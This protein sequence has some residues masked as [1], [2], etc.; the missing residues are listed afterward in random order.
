MLWIWTSQGSGSFLVLPA[1]CLASTILGV[2]WGGKTNVL[3][4]CHVCPSARPCMIWYQCLNYLVGFHETRYICSLQNV[5]EKTR[6]KSGA[7]SHTFLRT[8]INVC[9]YVYFTNFVISLLKFGIEDNSVMHVDIYEFRWSSVQW[10]P[11]FTEGRKLNCA[12]ILYI[13]LRI[14]LK[15]SACN[16]LKLYWLRVRRGNM[17]GEIPTLIV[18]TSEFLFF[19]IQFP[20]W[21]K[22]VMRNLNTL[23]LNICDFLWKS[24][25]ERS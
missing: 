17:L 5:V 3:F 25:Q 9:L 12:R 13:F 15:F 19:H 10:K 2:P 21:V 23:M 18:A 4:G 7:L 22:F 14:Y 16:V 6:M 24:G 8:K 11:Y 1:V 20:F